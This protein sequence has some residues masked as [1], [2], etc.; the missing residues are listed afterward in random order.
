MSFEA[1]FSTSICYGAGAPETGWTLA[2]PITLPLAA[3]ALVYATGANRLWRRSS[4]GR[5]ERIRQTLLFAAG[6][7]VLT[8]A[9]VS[10]IHALGERVFAAHMIEHELLMALAAPL[11]VAARPGAALVWALPVAFRQRTGR[12][13]HGKMLQAVWAFAS[14]PLNATIIHAI[15]IWIWHIPFL[16]EAALQRGVLHYT[17]HASFLGT[18]LLFWWAL[19]P[20]SGRQQAYGSAVMH[21]FFTSMHT[22]LL[23]VLLLLSPKLWYPEN[24]G[25]AALWGLSPIEDQQLAGLVM[26]VPAGL[27][28]GGAA[29]LLAGLWISKSG[30]REAT[31][32]L[33][34]G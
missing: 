25:G 5:P 30:T 13:T 9:L 10:P 14:R 23:G 33:R 24:A 22:G 31:H 17:Q 16:F 2:L 6:W 11:L 7:C 27:I 4:R 20:G 26:W 1:F 34:S 12:L 15:A 8:G 18:A 28:Y 32:A 19:L 29:L 3:L 21:L